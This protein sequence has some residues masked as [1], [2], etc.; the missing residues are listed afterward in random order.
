MGNAIIEG[1]VRAA[2][3][4]AFTPKFLAT[5]DARGRPNCVP[6]ISITPYDDATV[7][8][9]EFLM[10]KTRVNLDA[11]PEVCIAVQNEAFESW[12]ILGRFEGWETK[13]PRIDAINRSPMFRYNAYTSVRAAGT[14]RVVEIGPMQRLSKTRM[15]ARYAFA[16]ALSPWYAGRGAAVN[17]GQDGPV[18]VMPVRV[19]E[20]FRRLGAVRAVA[21][22][23]GADDGFPRAFVVMPCVA[24]G[25]QRLLFSDPRADVWLERAPAGVEMA[26]AVITRDAIA[27]QVKGVYRGTG[28][29][30]HVVD[31]DACYSASPPLAGDRLDPIRA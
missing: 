27:Y 13:G 15:I 2:L 14:I 5:L 12:S 9:G 20:K 6:V 21:F 30:V 22:R 7:I 28:A 16:R 11:R 1:G 3:A 23:E 25:G 31:L 18:P 29:G 19:R 8:F 10:N 24:A 4:G 26:V 17:R